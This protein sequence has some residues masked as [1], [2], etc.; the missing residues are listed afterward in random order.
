[1]DL[2]DGLTNWRLLSSPFWCYKIEAQQTL[3]VAQLEINQ[4]PLLTSYCAR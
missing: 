1:M 3:K 2:L 4:K